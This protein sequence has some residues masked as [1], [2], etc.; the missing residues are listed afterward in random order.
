M[1]LLGDSGRELLEQAG[2]PD[3]HFAANQHDRSGVGDVAQRV[4][5]GRERGLTPDEIRGP[6]A[7]PHDFS[8][9][10]IRSERAKSAPLEVFGVLVGPSALRRFT[11]RAQ[12]CAFCE[13]SV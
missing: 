4:A 1:R 8:L 2:L 3:A 7:A 10:A 6:L 12:S 9:W 5:E 11:E 13:L